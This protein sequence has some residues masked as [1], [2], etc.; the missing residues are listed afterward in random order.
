VDDSLSSK[1]TPRT[2]AEYKAAIDL[3]LTEMHRL[4]QQMRTDE[5]AIDRL[6]TETETLKRETRALLASMGAA[7]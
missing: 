6:K 1:M 2:D 7:V 3:L 4:N 5:A